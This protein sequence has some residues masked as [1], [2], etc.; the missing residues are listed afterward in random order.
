[1][2]ASIVYIV[3]IHLL[4]ECYQISS[5]TL[6]GKLSST[7]FYFHPRPMLFIFESYFFVVFIVVGLLD[8]I[9]ND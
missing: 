4:T 9:M 3:L 8:V 7:L 1:M 2:S 5:Q 6:Q